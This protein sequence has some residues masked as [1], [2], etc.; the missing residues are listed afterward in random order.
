MK[1]R[2]TIEKDINEIMNIIKQA[3][4]YL[5]RNDIP[6]WQ[7]GY[8][9]VEVIKSDIE[10]GYSYVLIDED[11]VVG[12]AAISFEGEKT[13]DTIYEGEWLS[14]YD[15]AVV[16]RIAIH[17]DC[18]GK[19]IAGIIMGSIENMCLDKGVRS[20][21]IDTQ[22]KNISMQ[23]MITNNGFKYCGIIY[24]EDGS[25]RFAY[26]KILKINMNNYK[27]INNEELQQRMESES[28]NIIDIRE[29][30]EYLVGHIPGALSM[31]LSGLEDTINDLNLDNEYHLVCRTGRRVEV[32]IRIFAKNGFRRIVKVIPGMSEWDGI[33]EKGN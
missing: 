28:I 32:S 7:N 12:T 21:K 27:T 3:Q 10:K 4:E 8:P 17:S 30:D 33:I 19:G 20:I 6:Q 13:Y 5:K 22:R 18:K 14:N 15:Y 23:N 26:E 25:E 11:K 16:H 9:G 31:P 2:R 1:L 29:S 24:L